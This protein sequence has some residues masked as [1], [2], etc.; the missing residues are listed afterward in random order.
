MDTL[1]S[2]EELLAALKFELLKRQ[3]PPEYLGLIGKR[4][5]HE[6]PQDFSQFLSEAVCVEDIF[7]RGEYV[8]R[9]LKET[10]EVEQAMDS[11]NLTEFG[12]V[13][14]DLLAGKTFVDLACGIP[15]TE[16]NAP[17]V[18]AE[19][20]GAKEYLGVEA[21]LDKDI[22]KKGKN[23]FP[24]FFLK[25]D[26]LSFVSKFQSREGG[27]VFYLS[28]FEPKY[29]DDPS[30]LKT[31]VKNNPRAVEEYKLA[32]KYIKATLTEIA[33]GAKPGDI[34]IIGQGTHGFEPKKFG[35]TLVAEMEYH[36]IYQRR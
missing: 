21:K 18:I 2:S 25:D 9:V 5:F 30:N 8:S 16:P 19:A 27:T 31:I 20:F 11:K 6:S 10:G 4:L 15:G 1:R 13:L 32:K 28:G 23:D 34:I 33:N 17:R 36:S 14:K 7:V 29:I 24:E 35:F 26:V 22:H 3:I 12:K